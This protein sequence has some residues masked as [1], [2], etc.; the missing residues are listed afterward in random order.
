[1]PA[2][3]VRS[4]DQYAVE[5]L[6]EIIGRGVDPMLYSAL[7]GRRRLAETLSMSYQAMRYG[8]AILIF[9]TQDPRDLA[10]AKREAKSFLKTARERNFSR[11]DFY[12]EQ[13]L[14]ATD[15][16]A[17]AKNQIRIRPGA[18]RKRAWAWPPPWPAI[19]SLAREAPRLPISRASTR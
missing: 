2:P 1:M 19:F 5:L 15:Y 12:G 14:R 10:G 18:P 8:G 6:T 4:S 3:D 9:I 13:Q 7:A 17:S 11:D 16:L